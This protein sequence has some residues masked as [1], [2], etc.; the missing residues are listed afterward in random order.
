[1]D[2][3]FSNDLD[4]LS[5]PAFRHPVLISAESS[6]PLF[7]IF[8][9]FPLLKLILK[10]PSWVT[11]RTSSKSLGLLLLQDTIGKQLDSFIANPKSLHD[12]PHPIIYHRLLD[13]EITRKA[14]GGVQGHLP[15]EKGFE[16]NTGLPSRKSLLEEAQALFLAGS[17]TVG[18]T[19]SVG[20]FYILSHPHVYQRLVA[21]LKENWVDINERKLYQDLEKLPFLVSQ[22]LVFFSWL[23]FTNSLAE[24]YPHI[25]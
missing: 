2:F 19:L 12:I 18:N 5:S 14:F 9:H 1:M 4:A 23:V 25:R 24:L 15:S 20:S 3:G 13:P 8:R 17:D 21:E 10:L 11:L 16:M 7:W 6:F 22:Y